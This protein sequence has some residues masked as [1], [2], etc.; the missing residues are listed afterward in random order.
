[1]SYVSLFT[2]LP[3]GEAHEQAQIRNATAGALWIWRALDHK[4]KTRCSILQYA[5][6]WKLFNSGK[7]S[8]LD[9]ITLGISFDRVWVKK[10]NLPKLIEAL[11]AFSNEFCEQP[12]QISSPL[13][14]V[15]AQEGP[16]KVDNTI[17]R[18][19]I[20]LTACLEMDILGVAFNHTSVGEAFW[21]V[22]EQPE[23]PATDEELREANIPEDEWDDCR[24]EGV[25]RGYN[26][27][28]DTGEHWE[29]FEAI[30]EEMPNQ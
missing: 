17:P 15:S 21:E 14:F 20:A 18:L 24:Y 30:A 4:Y 12:V 29:L 13:D 23:K 5:K 27:L 11:K 16:V 10:E 1:M 19:I 26:I 28:T 6:L 22:Y 7:L 25:Y 8:E 3:N 2:F 9:N